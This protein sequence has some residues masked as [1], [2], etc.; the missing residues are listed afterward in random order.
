MLVPVPGLEEEAEDQHQA[1]VTNQIESA[2]PMTKVDLDTTPIQTQA[3]L[4]ASQ[5]KALS[6]NMNDSWTKE[7]FL[8][9]CKIRMILLKR[10][11]LTLFFRIVF[12]IAFII[13][14]AALLKGTGPST[15]SLEPPVLLLGSSYYANTSGGDRRLPDMI[16]TQPPTGQYWGNMSRML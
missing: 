8:A 7:S 6:T 15:V 4:D 11:K 5:L 3:S 12:P 14:G 1:D 10:S 9:L 2:E 13:G 16:Y